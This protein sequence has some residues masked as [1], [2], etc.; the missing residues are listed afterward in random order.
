MTESQP[1]LLLYSYWR[2]SSAYRVRI[3]LSLKG[4]R[5]GQEPVHL[6]RDGGEQNSPDYR[7]LNP[8][9][10]VPALVH[11]DRVIVES[12][13]IC[14]YLDEL[15]PEPALLP[16]TPSERARVR[17]LALGIAC[18]IQPLNN[19]AVLRYLKT[20]L[21]ADDE[22]VKAWYT[23]WVDR[24]FSAIEHWLENDGLAGDFCHGDTPG[25]ADCFLVPQV[26][27]AERFECDL[28]PYPRIREI[29]ARCRQRQEFIAAAPE[30]QPDAPQEG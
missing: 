16:D 30:N 10:L 28:G 26:Y 5:F 6:V 27:N 24:G 14:E 1:G 18:E 22:A 21:G 4:L 9:G 11:D 8:L 25:L 23:R 19:L 20:G 12:M 15:F 2:S 29:A 7:R 3:A 13:A 17:A